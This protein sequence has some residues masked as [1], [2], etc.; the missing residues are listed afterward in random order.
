MSL[1]R[2]FGRMLADSTKD[3][4]SN[5]LFGREQV[6]RSYRFGR[7]VERTTMRAGGLLGIKLDAD[8][9]GRVSNEERR[10]AQRQKEALDRVG[11][12]LGFGK[13]PATEDTAAPT[14]PS[15]EVIDAAPDLPEETAAL[16]IRAMILAAACDGEIDPEERAKI[17]G[18][19]ADAP[20]G[21]RAF[22]ARTLDAP[23]TLDAL[24]A[25]APADEEMRAQLY[26]ASLAAIE[27]DT[28]E[29]E[30]HMRALAAGLGLPDDVV[31]ALHAELG[32]APL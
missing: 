17:E 9:D 12:W 23:G 14:D 5:K 10:R 27:I 31:T 13:T 16:L 2:T 30:A 19:V 6:V 4:F 32:R 1:A 15:P 22:V 7:P 20:D 29:E 21:D 8:G 24:L 18:H 3:H 25:D 26:L 28:P 11:S